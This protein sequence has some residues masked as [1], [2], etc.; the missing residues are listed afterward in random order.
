MANRYVLIPS[1]VY[2][3]LA[4]SCTQE[5]PGNKSLFY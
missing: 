3:Q 1:P 5:I 4:C 2:W